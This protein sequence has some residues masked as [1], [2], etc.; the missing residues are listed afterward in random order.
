M[1]PLHKRY[2]HVQYHFSWALSLGSDKTMVR[3]L[4]CLRFDISV[5]NLTLGLLIDAVFRLQSLLPIGSRGYVQYSALSPDQLNMN[6]NIN[7]DDELR[8][9]NTIIFFFFFRAAKYHFIHQRLYVTTIM[10]ILQKR[11]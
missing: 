3:D 2:I 1:I 11:K 9:M 8:N 4:Y 7:R 10:I 6:L 5:L